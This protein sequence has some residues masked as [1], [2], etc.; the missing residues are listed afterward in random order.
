VFCVP[1]FLDPT[2]PRAGFT[3][4]LQRSKLFMLPSRRLLGGKANGETQFAF[5]GEIWQVWC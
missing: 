4:L 2:Q 3:S 5:G 1:S